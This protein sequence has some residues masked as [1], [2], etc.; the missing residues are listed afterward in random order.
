MGGAS[1]DGTVYHRRII[2]AC[3]LAV[4]AWLLTVRRRKFRTNR[5]YEEVAGQ[6]NNS[7]NN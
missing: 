6:A 1:L 7:K 5:Q 4:A 3:G 2:D